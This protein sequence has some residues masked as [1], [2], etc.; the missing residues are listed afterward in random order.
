[1]GILSGQEIY[2]QMR[3]GKINIDPF[4]E[5]LLG[6][7]SYDVH[8]SDMLLS[9]HDLT[10]DVTK[11]PRDVREILIPEEGF[12]L[13]PGVL[14]LGATIERITSNYFVPCLDG[15]STIGRYGLQVHTTAGK[16]D[17]GFDGTFTCE[18]TTVARPLRIFAGMRFAQ[19]S[20][21]V[22]EGERKPYTGSYNGQRGPRL[23]KPLGADDFLIIPKVLDAGQ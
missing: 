8:L 10:L 17:D 21:L 12:V 9:I 20:F 22:L 15:R 1:M 19:I 6:P 14:Y 18:L 3:L 11:S 5:R 23:P 4:E 7:N 16:G 13:E 2:M